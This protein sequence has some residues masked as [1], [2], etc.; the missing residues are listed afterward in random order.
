MPGLSP[1]V[2]LTLIY[3]DAPFLIEREAS[4]LT[5]ALLPG[6]AREYGLTVL[7]FAANSLDEAGAHLRT[8]SLIAET[9]VVLLRNLQELKAD[10][11][12]KLAGWC[13][14]IPRATYVILTAE[15]TRQAAQKG[16]PAR[17]ALKKVI[18]ASGQSAG[19][20]TPWESELAG[21]VVQ[22]AQRLGTTL[23]RQGAELLVE[24]VGRDHARLVSEV[25]KLA[26]YVGGASGISVDDVRTAASRSAE[27]T[28]FQLVDAIA[29]GNARQALAVLPDLVPAH[30]PTSAAIPL[31]GMI[32]RNIRLLWQASYLAKN[33]APV[34]RQGKLRDDLAELLPN[35]HNVDAATRSNFVARKLAGHARNFDDRQAAVALGRVLHADRTL[36]GQ[37]DEYMD[38]RLV[39][40]RL[41][42]ELCMLARS[43]T[44]GRR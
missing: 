17:A 13:S 20:I 42:I 39:V 21:W 33:G 15:V 23:D 19:F 36:K 26:C 29:E 3:G 18:E 5:N 37:T 14:E 11:Q 7:D 38:P 34:D 1:E 31:L 41:V 40:E 44:G 10:A 16:N 22:E 35:E 9:R 25:E 32:A 28:V 2:Q 43:A 4:E 27:A 6:A 12:K 24:M 8:G 30:S